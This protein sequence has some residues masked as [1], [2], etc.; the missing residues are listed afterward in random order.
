MQSP[1]RFVLFVVLMSLSAVAFAQSDREARRAI[2]VAPVPSEAQK[3]FATLKSRGRVG[4]PR[5]RRL[6][7]GD[8]RRQ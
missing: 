2:F 6:C 5:H 4:R 7:A 8:V 1:I 3:S